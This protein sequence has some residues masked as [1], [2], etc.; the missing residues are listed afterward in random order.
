MFIGG[1]YYSAREESKRST[2]DG[3]QII[4]GQFQTLAPPEHTH[5][6]PLIVVQILT[7][8]N[9]LGTFACRTVQ[10]TVNTHANIHPHTHIIERLRDINR[11]REGRGDRK[12]DRVNEL[13]SLKDTENIKVNI[14][15]GP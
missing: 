1:R 2:F 9:S 7:R 13:S 4:Y 10:T 14:V 15:N 11:L 5:R 6:V 3:Q 8:K 12:E